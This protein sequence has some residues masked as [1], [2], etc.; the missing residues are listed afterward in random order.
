M[1]FYKWPISL[2]MFEHHREES[3]GLRFNSSWEELK[4]FSLSHIQDM[5]K[6]TSFSV[7]GLICP[8]H[9]LE[10]FQMK[11][12]FGSSPVESTTSNSGPKS[13]NAQLNTPCTPALI[14]WKEMAVLLTV[15]YFYSQTIKY[16]T[17]CVIG[18]NVG[19]KRGTLN[20]TTSIETAY[21][22]SISNAVE[23]MQCNTTSYKSLVIG[24]L[25]LW[26]IK[27]TTHIS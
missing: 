16:S 9:T 1:W 15:V 23:M 8:S 18:C 17:R 4:I 25:S 7:N 13:Q 27:L 5:K 2:K 3:K 21:H 14:N 19:K 22:S 6:K 12:S 11:N 26:L 10:I 24:L 20:R